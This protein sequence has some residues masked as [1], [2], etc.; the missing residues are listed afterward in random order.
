MPARNFEIRSS[1]VRWHG[2]PLC[3]FGAIS[4]IGIAIA[5][6]T[7][8]HKTRKPTNCGTKTADMPDKKNC[9]YF[10]KK[11]FTIILTVIENKF[12]ILFHVADA[13]N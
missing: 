12:K 6:N 7:H 3:D 10:N 1:T 9:I 13:Q 2:S 8:T 11:K 4:L 5:F